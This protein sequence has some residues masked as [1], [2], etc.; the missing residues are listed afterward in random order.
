MSADATT[1]EVVDGL[2]AAYLAGDPHGMLA[3]FADDIHVRFLGQADLHGIEDAT[4]FFEF[5]SGLLVDLEFRIER[6][7][8]DGEW[9]AVT[10]SE[11]ART[12]DGAPWENHGVDVI[13]VEDGEIT[14]LHENNDVRL[15]RRHLPRYR[16]QAANGR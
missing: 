16:D 10:W 4:R 3:L 15:A 11:T 14:V 6:K 7:I 2:Y 8:V 9:A 13:R 5:A 12:A 1:R